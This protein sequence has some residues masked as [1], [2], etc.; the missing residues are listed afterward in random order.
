MSY[1]ER[2]HLQKTANL[3]QELAPLSKAI[4]ASLQKVHPPSDQSHLTL[5]VQDQSFELKDGDIIGRGGTVAA[6]LFSTSNVVSRKHLVINRDKN[7]WYVTVLPS[8]PNVTLM[9]EG[10]M[11]RGLKYPIVGQHK[12]NLAG[13]CVITLNLIQLSRS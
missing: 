2:R 1:Q 12:L 10:T 8:V 13:Q 3:S 6:H 4:H 9:D 5:E 7:G 11:Q